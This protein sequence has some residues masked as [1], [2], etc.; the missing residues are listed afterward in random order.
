MNYPIHTNKDDSNFYPEYSYCRM[1]PIVKGVRNLSSMFSFMKG[2][3]ICISIKPIFPT[4]SGKRLYVPFCLGTG[5]KMC[6][7]GSNVT[8]LITLVRAL[9][10]RDRY[11][12]LILHGIVSLHLCYCDILQYILK[13]W[14]KCLYSLYVYIFD[15]SGKN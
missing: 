11:R 9:H 1:K 2:P 10:E 6:E 12:S 14:L 5:D 3:L 8:H 4:H 7:V 13:G 15:L